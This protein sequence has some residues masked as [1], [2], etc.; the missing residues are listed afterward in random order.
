M[1]F[2][3]RLARLTLALNWR[4]REWLRLTGE[5]LRIDGART[6]PEQP[7]AQDLDDTQIQL[8]ARFLF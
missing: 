7:V 8:N 5:V 3:L 4:P 2:H 1:G 6:I